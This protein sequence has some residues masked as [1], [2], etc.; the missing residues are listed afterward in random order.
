MTYLF[1]LL[2]L[3]LRSSKDITPS[4]V[5][6]SAVTWQVGTVGNTRNHSQALD[7][8]G[9]AQSAQPSLPASHY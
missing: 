1:F 4:Q 5:L 6:S 7:T 8:L 9:T 3:A 2:R